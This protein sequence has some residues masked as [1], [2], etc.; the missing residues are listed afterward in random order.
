MPL[1]QQSHPTW[2]GRIKVRTVGAGHATYIIV[3]GLELRIVGTNSIEFL[4]G[5]MFK[6]PGSDKLHAND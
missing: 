3:F 1:E 4:K 5:R 6:R 2:D